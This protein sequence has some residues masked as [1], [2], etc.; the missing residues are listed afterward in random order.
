MLCVHFRIYGICLPMLWT[1]YIC[2]YIYIY[3]YIYNYIYETKKFYINILRVDFT[4]HFILQ[5]SFSANCKHEASNKSYVFK[6]FKIVNSARIILTIESMIRE[7]NCFYPR[8]STH[9]CSKWNFLSNLATG[10]LYFPDGQ[11]F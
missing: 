7:T 5:K 9:Y 3:I 10:S 6:E 8:P 11:N 4:F 1:Q 2:V